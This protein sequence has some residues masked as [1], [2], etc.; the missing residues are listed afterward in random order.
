MM[1][2]QMIAG[3]PGPSAHVRDRVAACEHNI[4]KSDRQTNSGPGFVPT[5]TKRFDIGDED[6]HVFGNDESEWYQQ[7]PRYEKGKHS[8]S[9][10]KGNDKGK[11]K[12]GSYIAGVSEWPQQ[13]HTARDY[14]NQG[15]EMSV[16]DSVANREGSKSLDAI[17]RDRDVIVVKQELE[18]MEEMIVCD[19]LKRQL[20]LKEHDAKTGHSRRSPNTSRASSMHSGGKLI[21]HDNQR[22]PL[23]AFPGRELP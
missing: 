9:K 7:S 2:G 8:H 14:R 10:G 12:G 3:R 22:S 13:T 5:G 19:E 15:D 18:R 11:S 6:D 21:V 4:K 23:R 20:V 1:S 17:K 16:A